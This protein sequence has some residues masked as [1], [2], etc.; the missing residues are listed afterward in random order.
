MK[1]DIR[2]MFDNFSDEEV[3]IT[4][5]NLV[6]PE[7]VLE[8]TM[9][10]IKEDNNM[11]KTTKNRLI[12]IPLIAAA[13]TAVIS[14]TAFAAH[15]FLT[16]T[17]IATHIEDYKLA[18]VLSSQNSD[19][20][21]EPQISG[22]YTIQLL[23]IVSGNDLSLFAE[24]FGADKKRSYIVGSLSRTDGKPLGSDFKG[25]MMTPLI[26]GYKPWQVNIFTLGGG[27]SEFIDDEDMVDYFI[28]ECDNLEYFADHTI[29]IAFYDAELLAP[30]SETFTMDADGSI[31]FNENY[32]GIKALFTLP[33][34]KSKADPEKAKALL[35]ETGLID[36]TEEDNTVTKDYI[37][38]K[39][40]NVY[41]G[42]NI[43]EVGQ[44]K[45]VPNQSVEISLG[46]NELTEG[47]DTVINTD[48]SEYIITTEKDADSETY[49]ITK[50]Q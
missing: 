27:K 43:S 48:D 29:Y 1:K 46:D 38:T 42:V 5:E 45:A 34:D 30:G 26:S 23:G 6:S 22:D 28:Y 12:S 33:M 47:N 36:D 15:K 44:A 13:V 9:K 8:L 40:D 35:D 24:D 31:R 2:D 4:A 3:N 17:E 7:R 32:T 16:P 25:V 37:V 14:A 10:K 39:D 18:D 50:K 11:N 49:I 21:I 20:Y 19:F 41:S